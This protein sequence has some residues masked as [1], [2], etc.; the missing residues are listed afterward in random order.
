[1]LGRSLLLLFAAACPL[2]ACGSRSELSLGDLSSTTSTTSSSPPSVQVASVALG[3][4][5]SC[6]VLTDGTAA[7]WGW[8]AYGQ[9]GTPDPPDPDEPH[10]PHPN[11]TTLAD[12]TQIAAIA[13]GYGHTCA[14]LH[15]GTLECWGNNGL[16][17]SGTGTD[18]PQVPPTVI[19]ADT[20]TI[21]TGFNGSCAVLHDGTAACWG[22]ND[23]G[24]L[25]DGTTMNRK[26]PVAVKGL[27]G[28]IAIDISEYHSCALLQSGGIECWGM[29]SEGALGDGTFDDSLTPVAVEGLDAPAMQIALGDQHTCALVEGGTVMFCT[30]APRAR[31]SWMSGFMNRRSSS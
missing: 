10:P 9:L 27:S 17:Q 2:F 12:P 3:W 19:G 30:T 11:P 6:A 4:D 24:Q 23:R 29:G 13:G 16:G 7:C 15:D 28:A 1:M 5:H 18:D 8:N 14:V 26:A 31:S 20:L 25:G 21:S 22:Y